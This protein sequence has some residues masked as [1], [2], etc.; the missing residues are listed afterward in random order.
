MAFTFKDTIF[1]L[2]PIRFKR[3]DSYI[4]GG[5]GFFQRYMEAFGEELDIEI[6]PQIGDYLKILNPIDTNHD[7]IVHIADNWANPPDTLSDSSRYRQLLAVIARINNLKGTKAGYEA[8]F[9]VLGLTIVITEVTPTNP[10]SYDSGG[11][12]DDTDQ[13]YDMPCPACSDYDLAITDSDNLYPNITD[14]FPL[15]DRIVKYLE[16]INARL[17]TLTWDGTPI[18][19]GGSYSQ[20]YSQ[21]YSH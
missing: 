11:N 1:T 6:Y 8:F 2:F 20:S 15:L 19:I 3:D 16:P 10:I 9:G 18:S 21:S 12:Y 7:F 4:V 13:N 14:M 5:K 17:Q